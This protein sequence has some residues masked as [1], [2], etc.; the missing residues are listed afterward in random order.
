MILGV[1]GM[2][3]RMSK[4]MAVGHLMVVVM[5]VVNSLDFRLGLDL[6]V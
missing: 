1:H 2:E 5:P 3:L 4:P 6:E